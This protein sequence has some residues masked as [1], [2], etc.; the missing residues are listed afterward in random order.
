MLRVNVV[1]GDDGHS[2]AAAGHLGS[3]AGHDKAQSAHL[4][5][6]V[7]S[8]HYSN[9]YKLALVVAPEGKLVSG[10]CGCFPEGM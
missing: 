2:S 10:M 4:V 3:A 5:G 1:A 9:C 7:R 6:G 8:A